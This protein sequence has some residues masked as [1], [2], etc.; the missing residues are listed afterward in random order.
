M[1]KSGYVAIIG[2]PNA[3]KS[4][5][6]NKLLGERL[7]IITSKPQTTRKR[8]LGILSDNDYQIIFLDTP[9]ILKPA[10]LLQE[11]FLEQIE[12]SVKDADIV[13]IIFDILEDPEC[14]DA[15][16]DEIISRV[17]PE[18]KFKKIA[19]L[20]K[21]DKSNQEAV[22][23]SLLKLENTGDFDF[24]IPVSAIKNF[25]VDVLLKKVLELL[26]EG[27]K[28]YPDDQITNENERFF[29]SEIIREKVFEQ[30]K[31]EIPFSTEVI[32]D[33]FRERSGRKDYISASI[34]VERD[35]QKPIIIGKGGEAIKKLGTLARE[36]LEEFLQR[37]VYLEIHVKVKNKWRS[38][39]AMLK[40]FGYNVERD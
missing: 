37:E 6:M 18:S 5:L 29:A 14:S 26:P 13:V 40:N 10:Y 38:N 34:I 11:K 20:N 31:D 12:I 8:I 4:T 24:V 35:S 30:Y 32:I 28:Y 27:P 16:Q 23:K 3:G 7:S 17:M 39:P 22:N 1:T 9:G 19:V 25:N 15:L 36:A 21:I 2:K 33:E